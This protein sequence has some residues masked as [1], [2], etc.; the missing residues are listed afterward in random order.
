MLS[1][2]T[3]EAKFLS[4]ILERRSYYKNHLLYGEFEEELHLKLCNYL[5]V[6]KRASS[7]KSQSS[8]VSNVEPMWS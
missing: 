5:Q 3:K 4:D 1:L 6:S 2:T 8:N 7:M